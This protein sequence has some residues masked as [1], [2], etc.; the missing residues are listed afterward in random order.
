ML[1]LL[2]LFSIILYQ[3][4][5]KKNSIMYRPNSV[6]VKAKSWFY[7]QWFLV[8]ISLV[9]F[10]ATIKTGVNDECSLSHITHHFPLCCYFSS[11]FE[12]QSVGGEGDGEVSAPH[13][14]ISQP[15]L[16]FIGKCFGDSCCVTACPWPTKTSLKNHWQSC[17]SDYLVAVI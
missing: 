15:R 5:L 4:P 14:T 3:Y 9:V 6:S 11:P 13:P 8:S 16:D 17:R 7:R 12:W 2:S 1:Y 10:W